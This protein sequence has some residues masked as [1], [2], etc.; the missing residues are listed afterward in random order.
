MEAWQE[1]QFTQ[2][3]SRII[4]RAIDL[5][6]KEVLDIIQLTFGVNTEG[7]YQLLTATDPTCKDQ[8]LRL[9]IGAFLNRLFNTNMK[10]ASLP[11]L[12]WES[13]L[14]YTT[15][16]GQQTFFI[17]KISA[18]YEANYID[19][20]TGTPKSSI[21]LEAEKESLYAVTLNVNQTIGIYTLYLSV[22][23]NEIHL[24]GYNTIY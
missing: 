4:A 17:Q 1:D 3:D 20:E 19:A 10:N 11:G 16:A 6:T 21:Y 2:E 23:N 22:E 12:G 8:D 24:L 5:E 14:D 15:S 9:E 7:C 18:P 13:S